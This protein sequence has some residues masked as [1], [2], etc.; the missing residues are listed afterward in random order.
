MRF[1][2]DDDFRYDARND[3]YV[4]P[5][6]QRLTR[7]G[8]PR[9][10]E[11]KR[12][13]RY[14][15]VTAVCRDCSLGDR[16]LTKSQSRRRLA[17][18]EHEDVIDRHRRKM[19]AGAPWMR[20]RAALFEHPFGTIKRWAGMDRFLMRGLEKCHG[21]FSLMTLG[22]NFKRVMNESGAEAFRE[23]CLQKQRTGTVSA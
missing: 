17:R 1:S 23:H 21:E 11:G 20:Q 18:W 6:G 12:Y 8:S 5:A 4:C 9:I 10:R 16:C 19:S 2:R 15:S 3:T 14:S 22:Y 13:F 7:R